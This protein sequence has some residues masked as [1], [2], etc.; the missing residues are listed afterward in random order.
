L[1]SRRQ[2]ASRSASCRRHASLLVDVV[3]AAVLGLQVAKERSHLT[4]RPNFGTFLAPFQQDPPTIQSIVCGILQSL[5]CRH[6]VPNRPAR[7]CHTQFASPRPPDKDLDPRRRPASRSASS[8]RQS[9]TRRKAEQTLRHSAAKE[10]S[11]ST[12][13]PNSASRSASRQRRSLSMSGG[14]NLDFSSDR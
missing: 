13:R 9:S 1:T 6:T 3:V 11:H 10:R 7:R 2:S 8:P 4:G 5:L 14:E 12:G